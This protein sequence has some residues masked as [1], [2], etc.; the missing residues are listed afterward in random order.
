[1]RA[2]WLMVWLAFVLASRS[3]AVSLL[4][5]RWPVTLGKVLAGCYAGAS[6]CVDCPKLAPMGRSW[7]FF[8]RDL[9]LATFAASS[10]YLSYSH[11]G[12]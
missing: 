8:S 1:M 3:I 11:L 12:R 7:I 5:Y 4:S 2:C 6:A 10:G 9:S